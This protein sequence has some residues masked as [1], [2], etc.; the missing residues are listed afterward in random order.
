MNLEIGQK[1]GKYTVTGIKTVAS[2][3]K[4]FK[5]T[6]I[7]HQIALLGIRGAKATAYVHKS[8]RV[9]NLIRGPFGYFEGESVINGAE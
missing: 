2:Y 1:W 4:Y 9:G 7:T 6:D 5:N 8:G 3:G